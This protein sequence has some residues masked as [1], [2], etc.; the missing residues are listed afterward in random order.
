MQGC[1]C[2]HSTM[3]KDEAGEWLECSLF[4]SSIKWHLNNTHF[5]RGRMQLSLSIL[6]S[7]RTWCLDTDELSFNWMSCQKSHNETY[8]WYLLDEK[9]ATKARNSQ[10]LELAQIVIQTLWSRTEFVRF[11]LNNPEIKREYPMKLGDI[12]AKVFYRNYWS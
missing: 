1:V 4:R 5:L 11:G 7:G 2:S 8:N 10:L 9:K 12:V 6:A 3:R